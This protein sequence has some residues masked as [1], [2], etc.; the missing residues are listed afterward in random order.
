MLSSAI[1]VVGLFLVLIF[2]VPNA[3]AYSAIVVA[4]MIIYALTLTKTR[5]FNMHDDKNYCSS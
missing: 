1:V 2:N 3:D 5:D 4:G